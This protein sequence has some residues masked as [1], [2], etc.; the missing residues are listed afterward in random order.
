MVLLFMFLALLWTG[1][2]FSMNLTLSHI[3]Q[4]Y[5]KVGDIYVYIYVYSFQIADHFR[6]MLCYCFE[7][8]V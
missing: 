7:R 1:V 6:G 4:Y 8:N 2:I 5:T 3:I